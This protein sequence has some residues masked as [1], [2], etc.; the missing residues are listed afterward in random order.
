MWCLTS[1]DHIFPSAKAHYFFQQLPTS[2]FNTSLDNLN[3]AYYGALFIKKSRTTSRHLTDK[4]D[5]ELRAGLLNKSRS[6]L[7]TPPFLG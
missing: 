3:I 1:V 6:H 5:E 2:V 4:A 7:A